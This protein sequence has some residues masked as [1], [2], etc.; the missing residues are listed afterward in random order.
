MS[1]RPRLAL[2]VS[3][4]VTLSIVASLLL[5]NYLVGLSADADD[6]QVLVLLYLLGALVGGFLLAGALD[7]MMVRPITDLASQVRSAADEGWREPLDL[8]R[9]GDEL[10]D[11]GRA[12]EELRAATVSQRE[13]LQ[14]RLDSVSTLAAGVAHE[15]NNPNGVVLSRVGYLLQ[16]A[17]EEGLDPDVIEDLQTIEHQA[18][19]VGS[20]ASGLLEFVRPGPEDRGPVDLSE[21][22]ALAVALLKDR[23]SQ[24][25][26]V[27]ELVARA[28][29]RPIGRRD[30]LEQVAF[31]LVKNAVECGATRVIVRTRPDGFE[32]VDDG[33]GIDDDARARIFEP[34]FTTKSAQGGT[35][36]GLAVS[37]G[38]VQDHGGILTVD[39]SPSGTTFR[40]GFP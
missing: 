26:V 32:V 2:R 7:R 20:V 33:P 18:R 25:G 22:L 11:L 28:A 9:Q 6:S 1:R 19:R 21:V 3:A 10:G 15:V 13:E 39:S 34:F 4:V 24:E 37:Y 27:L 23:A 35:G 17:D 36:L 5:V 12:L 16:I 38:I 8:P 40:V 30:R 31:N 14:Q 29:P